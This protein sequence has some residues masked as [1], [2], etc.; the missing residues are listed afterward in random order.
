MRLFDRIIL[1]STPTLVA[2]LY[3]ANDQLGGVNTLSGAA[4]DTGGPVLLESI[5]VLDKAKQKVAIDVFFFKSSPTLTS[6]DNQPFQL[7]DAEAAKCVGVVSIGALDYV[8]TVDS[9]LA[10]VLVQLPLQ[11]VSK[12][13]DLFYV[14]VTRGGPTYASASD[15]VFKFGIAKP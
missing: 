14:A 10:T 8:D 3:A 7:A 5:T 12:S 15:L 1:E 4:A 6:L 2:A 9:A 11:A 13:K